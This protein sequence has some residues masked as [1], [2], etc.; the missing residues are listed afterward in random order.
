MGLMNKRKNEV[1]DAINALTEAD[2]YLAEWLGRPADYEAI[3]DAEQL[4]YD[5][6]DSLKSKIGGS[7]E[8]SRR[9]AWTLVDRRSKLKRTSL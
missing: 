9:I 1:E 4:F 3:E 6:G 7:Q 5:I 2:L 8:L